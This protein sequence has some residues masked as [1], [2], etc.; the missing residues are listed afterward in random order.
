[1]NDDDLPTAAPR[2]TGRP[3]TIDP[4]AV[5]RIALQLFAD[6]GYER[7]S[8]EDIAREAG[9]GRKSLYRYFSTKADLIW[10]GIEPVAEAAGRA[11]DKISGIR[12]SPSSSDRVLAGCG[13]QSLL[14]RLSSRT[15]R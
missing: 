10:G 14:R 2:T 7:I 11:L 6:H 15:S 9:I 1:M 8:M 3:V 13:M 5:A 4:D 12:E